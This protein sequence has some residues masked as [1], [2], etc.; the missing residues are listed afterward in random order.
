MPDDLSV[1]RQYL[2]D[3][4]AHTKQQLN[5]LSQTNMLPLNLPKMQAMISKQ[6]E[7]FRQQLK[8]QLQGQLQ[9]Q[10]QEKLR[11]DGLLQLPRQQHQQLTQQINQLNL[12]KDQLNITLTDRNRRLR[13][14]LDNFGPW[15]F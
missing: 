13:T 15:E 2:Q 7:Q 1:N 11:L 9:Q 4:L 3:Y 14:E 8:D 12:Q 5:Q 10:Q 6:F